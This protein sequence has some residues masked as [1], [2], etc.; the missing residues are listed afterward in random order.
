[1]LDSLVSYTSDIVPI[2]RSLLIRVLQSPTV[3]S[4]FWTKVN[5]IWGHIVQSL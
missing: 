4:R 2:R 5:Q 1:M 3:L